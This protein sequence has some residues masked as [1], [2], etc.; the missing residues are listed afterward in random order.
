MK[1]KDIV[2]GATYLTYIG[3]NLSRVVVVSR[4]EG[5][6]TSPF[7]SNRRLSFRVRREDETTVLPKRRSA[8]ALREIAPQTKHVKHIDVQ[9]VSASDNQLTI[10]H[11]DLNSPFEG[12]DE[13]TS[14]AMPEL[15][16]L[17]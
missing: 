6:K 12:G 14:A 4:V 7:A 1:M 2:V 5:D 16:P 3:S 15:P 9:S 8:A 11:L 13:F 10:T 17:P